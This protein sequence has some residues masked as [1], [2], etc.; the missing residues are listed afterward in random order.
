MKLKS[1]FVTNSSSSS[2]I[3]GKSKLS[4]LQIKVLLDYNHSGDN[5]DCWRITDKGD[6]ISAYTLMDNDKID[7]FLEFIGVNGNIIDWIY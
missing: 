4:P 2:F 5:W 3:I 7:E 6:Y 1:D